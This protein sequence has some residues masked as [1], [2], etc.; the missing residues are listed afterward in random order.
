MDIQWDLLVAKP[1][2]PGMVALIRDKIEDISP[3]SSYQR[4]GVLKVALKKAIELK[5][6]KKEPRVLLRCNRH[7]STHYYN[8]TSL[9]KIGMNPFCPCSK[10]G[11]PFVYWFVCCNCGFE[12]KGDNMRCQN[13]GRSF[14]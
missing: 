6:K 10:P 2:H 11:T 14:L 5:K 4:A 13:C 1:N 3:W 12:R 7:G 8:D 9:S